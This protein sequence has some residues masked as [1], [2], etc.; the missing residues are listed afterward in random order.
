MPLNESF[1]FNQE[2]DAAHQRL[3]N[4]TKLSEH[5]VD[6]TALSR[7][8]KTARKK[9]VEMAQIQK[10]EAK[11]AAATNAHEAHDIAV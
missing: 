6:L 10:A 2:R 8:I 7:A 5:Q 1:L 3:D 9:G 11:L 4:H